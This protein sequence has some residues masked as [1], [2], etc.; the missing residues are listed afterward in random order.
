MFYPRTIHTFLRTLLAF[1][2]AITVFTG[3]TGA[4]VHPERLASASFT[5][6]SPAEINPAV[7]DGGRAQAEE[8]TK[9][10]VQEA[11]SKLPMRFEANEGQT[12]PP[13]KFLSRGSGYTLLLTS[14]EAVLALRKGG[15]GEEFAS[16]SLSEKTQAATLQMRLVGANPRPKIEGQEQLVGKSNYLIGNDRSKWHTNVPHFARVKYEGVYPGVDLVYYGTSQRQLEYDLLLAPGAATEQIRIS[17]GGVDKMSLDAQGNLMLETNAGEVMQRAPVIYQEVESGRR[18]VEGRYILKGKGEVGFELAGYDRARPL[19]IDPQIVYATFYGGSNAD[20]ARGVA[21]DANG[22]AYITGRTSSPDLLLRNA[23][24]GQLKP[25]FGFSNDEFDAFVTKF[26]TDGTDII[27]STYIGGQYED[28][29]NAI[30]T[31]SDG[32]AC[33][34]GLVHNSITD[35]SFPVKNQFQGNGVFFFGVGSRFND[36]FLTVLTADGSDLSYSTF[37]AG[38]SSSTVGGA[39]I[40]RGDDVG[41]GIAVDTSNKI[42]ITGSSNANDL[43][44]KSAFQSARSASSSDRPDAF[45]AKFDPSKS[46][47]SSLIYSSYLGGTGTDVSRGVAVDASGNAYIAGFTASTNFPVRAPDSLGPFED[48]NQGGTDGF[49][50]KVSPSGS[51]LTYA[52]Y[53]GGSG[54]DRALA[55]ASDSS[56]RAYVTGFTD[57]PPSSFTGGGFGGVFDFRLQNAFD[58]TQSNGEAFV[59]KFNA[60]GSA[61]FYSSYLGGDGVDEGRGI[62]I[63][64]A[65]SAY[66]TGKTT[67]SG[68]SFPFNIDPLPNASGQTFITKIGPSD[69][70][71]TIVPPIRYSATF[72]GANT[73]GN[74]VD[75]DADGNIYVAGT[76]AGSLVA[77]PG[78]F[79]E[80]LKGGTDAFVAKISSTFT[81]TRISP[82]I[83]VNDPSQGS[84]RVGQLQQFLT[85]CSDPDGWHDISTIDFTI[86]RGRGRGAS[87]H[88]ILWVQFDENNNL[89]NFYNPETGEWSSGAPGS[90]TILS[91]RF[92]ELD[93]S[94]TSVE[95]SGQTGPSVQIRWAITFKEAAVSNGYNQYLR[96]TDDVGLSTGT[97]KVGKWSI[98]P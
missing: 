16:P 86:T 40:T 2:L 12:D 37:F 95:G 15:R 34:T 50:A 21:V 9:A 91:S 65:G 8:T 19:V 81:P 73:E 53:F 42:Y 23:F 26:N 88:L 79:Q 61:V 75:I 51:T 1:S 46:G 48:F 71:G 85:T 69:A 56:Q 35:S 90:P 83:G 58:T 36:A 59:A 20:E 10:Q 22:N 62:V 57:S 52:T 33:I 77:T 24:Q 39:E 38:T 17:F 80:A 55:I 96:I 84:S 13:V 93:L 74:A 82:N 49:V 89:I 32:R 44:T 29:G 60:N 14:E 30:A 68:A 97:D 18:E 7:T 78:A 64:P 94:Q 31:M 47:N 54:T 28:T 3:W 45:I 76:S 92:A 67:S 98:T 27:Y 66:V 72:G 5:T 25:P 41:H 11:Y 6:I 87:E 4:P 63:D 43:P 70:T